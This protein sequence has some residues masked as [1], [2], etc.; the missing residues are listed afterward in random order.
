MAMQKPDEKAQQW[1]RVLF[2]E[3]EV[4]SKQTE[5]LKSEQSETFANTGERFCQFQKLYEKQFVGYQFEVGPKMFR[6]SSFSGIMQKSN[7]KCKCKKADISLLKTRFT[8]HS[9]NQLQHK[10]FR[11]NVLFLHKLSNM[12]FVFK[13]CAER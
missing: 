4:F 9:E 12:L 7:Q 2:V 10:F 13:N 1:W 3:L 5:T 11:N 8:G 6:N